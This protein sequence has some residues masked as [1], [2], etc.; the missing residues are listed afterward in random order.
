MGYDLFVVTP[1]RNRLEQFREFGQSVDVPC[2]ALT[3]YPPLHRLFGAA[4][5]RSWNAQMSE[6]STGARLPCA[7]L[8]KRPMRR[9]DLWSSGSRPNR[10]RSFHQFS[11]RT[12]TLSETTY[13]HTQRRKPHVQMS[14]ALKDPTSSTVS[15]ARWS[16]SDPPKYWRL[17][18]DGN[19]S[20]KT[21]WGHLRA[22]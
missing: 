3:L 10:R 19:P 22:Q 17:A 20:G 9:G 18:A 7:R 11:E 6:A 1:G 16:A 5:Q 2:V 12:P 13:R 8:T 14:R 21:V 15:G 4:V